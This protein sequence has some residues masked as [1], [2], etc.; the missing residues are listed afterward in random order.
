MF[1]PTVVLMYLIITNK[2][3]FEKYFDKDILTKLSISNKALTK[4]T[5]NILFFIA[6]ILMTLALSRPVIDEKE[7]SF[8]QEVASM[9]I[10]IDVSKSMLATDLY[11][12]RLTFAKQKVLDIIDLSK[13]NAI[14]VILF[15]KYS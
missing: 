6:V 2:D 10:A 11:P 8:K 5:R 4:T 14:A 3:T 13:K 9:V 12:N 7:Q 1:I 15:A